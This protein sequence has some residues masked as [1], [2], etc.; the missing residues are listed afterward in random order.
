MMSMRRAIDGKSPDEIKKLSKDELN[1]PI[2]M[3]DFL[4]AVKKINRSVSDDDL[5]KHQKWSDEFGSK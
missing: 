5:Q 2:S 1:L 4:D 3:K